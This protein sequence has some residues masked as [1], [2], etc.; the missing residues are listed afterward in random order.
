MSV[1]GCKKAL[2]V[3]YCDAGDSGPVVGQVATI[4][5]SPTLATV[6]ES[7]SFGQIGQALSATAYD[8][9]NNTVSVGKYTFATT[10]MTIADINPS[11]GAVC[12]G[13]WNRNS[14]GGIVDYTFCTAPA[15]TPSVY[16]AYVTASTGGAVSNSIPVFVHPTVTSI[17]LGNPT[18]GAPGS[19]ATVSDPGT[20]CCPANTSTV[21]SPPPTPYTQNSCISQGSTAQLIARVYA[22]GGT[23]PADN[24]T[25][26]VGHLT[27]SLPTA[28]N[29]ATIDQ[30]GVA[31]ANQPGSTLVAASV[32]NSSSAASAGFFSTCPP[33][34]IT[35]SVPGSTSNTV[36]VNLNNAQPLVATVR[37]KNNTILNNATLTGLSLE[38]EST[39]PQ[40]APATSST[41][42]PVFPGTAAITALCQPATCNPSAFSQ[43]GYLGNG[44][45]IQSNSIT[46]NTAGTSST[47]I[48][49]ASTQSQ[50]ILP[51]D[52]STGL[53][54]SQVKLPYAPNSMV[55]SLDGS[56]LYM[57]STQ[58]MMTLSTLS[59]SVSGPNLNLPGTVLSVSPDGTTVVITDPVRQTISLYQTSSS[60]VTT[61]IGG[62]GTRAVWSPDSQTVYITTTTNALLTHSNFTNWQTTTANEV[63]TDAVVMVPSIGA[64]FAGG[65]PGVNSGVT[66]DGRS[67]CAASAQSP[68]GTPPTETNTFAPL[69]ETDASI[70]D[71]LAATNIGQH[72][73][74]AH[75]I[76]AGT[77]TFTDLQFS[78]PTQNVSGVV[79]PQ[80]CPPPTTV[81]VPPP[82]TGYFTS[83]DSTLPLT[84]APAINA[85]TITGVLPSS[86]QVAPP[87]NL[88][89]TQLAAMS[90][91]VTFV[92]YTGTGGQLPEY[93]LPS[94]GAAG[95]LTYIPLAGTATAPI[96]GV[97]S[98]DNNTFYTGTS[99][100]NEVHEITQT[101]TT[102]AT[103]VCTWKD[104]GQLTPNLPAATGAGTVPVNLI[105]QKPKR[106]TS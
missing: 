78:F 104:T 100:D 59:N 40:T 71:K 32:S 41:I 4:T 89:A 5:L 80:A 34:S 27:F 15:T 29:V 37:D 102:A 68:A 43:I 90:N 47:V 21:Y 17:V 42:I 82:S 12:A 92:T 97:W 98:T 72:I 18:P 83:T 105:A 54:S 7:L 87:L 84:S 88:S 9:H 53:Q 31:T 95:T 6:G 22:F 11:N 33:T 14:G 61:V 73:L 64:Y 44:Q 46:I 67:Y 28:Q 52:F 16:E 26:Q 81:G 23:T 75:A 65:S 49:L 106:V 62:I 91:E 77:S 20:D 39:T 3:D 13:T 86:G 85:S 56:I 10:N 96:S 76:P 19:C 79:T 55:I 45:P 25:C 35:L 101:C 74:G 24:I 57:G 30:N 58:G 66:T 69:A 99:G 70:T 38:F 36:S 63:Y 103:P 60:N 1:S 2:A 94:S 51:V 93:L 50:Y 8:C 48:Y